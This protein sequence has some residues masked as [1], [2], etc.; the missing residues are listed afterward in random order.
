MQSVGIGAA[1]PFLKGVKWDG[2]KV[3]C[4][5]QKDNELKI[6][7][8]KYCCVHINLEITRTQY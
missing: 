3:H 7:T 1:A 5:T 8:G 6:R 2:W 4:I